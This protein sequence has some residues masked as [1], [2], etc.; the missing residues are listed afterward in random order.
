MLKGVEGLK[1]EIRF[2]NCEMR[3]AMISNL[4][5]VQSGAFQI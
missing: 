2:E 1:F 4:A 3:I 5:K